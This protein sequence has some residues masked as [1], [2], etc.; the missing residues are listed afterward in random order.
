[1]MRGQYRG[2]NQSQVIEFGQ[3]TP[4]FSVDVGKRLPDLEGYGGIAWWGSF[5][6]TRIIRILRRIVLSRDVVCVYSINFI[7]SGLYT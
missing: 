7:E 1:M 5:L 4:S 6:L 2:G 3:G